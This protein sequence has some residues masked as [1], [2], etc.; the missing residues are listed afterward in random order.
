MEGEYFYISFTFILFRF[1]ILRYNSDSISVEDFEKWKMDGNIYR[2]LTLFLYP[3]P[4]I[5]VMI[6]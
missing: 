6:K 3:N 5:H 1:S 2:N 4:A